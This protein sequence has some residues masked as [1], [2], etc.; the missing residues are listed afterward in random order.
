MALVIIII[1]I[2]F[3]IGAVI[4]VRK[5]LKKLDEQALGITVDSS[6]V[7]TAQE[8]LPFDNISENLLDLGGF[9]Y[10][11]IIE[12]SSINYHLKTDDEKEMIEASFARFLNSLQFPITIYIQTREIDLSNYLESLRTS[13]DETVESFPFL[14]GY[15][16]IFYNEMSRLPELTGN[17]KQKK[18]YII[19]GYDEIGKVENLNDEEKRNDAI[20]ELNLRVQLIIDG[21]SGMNIKATELS[22]AGILELLYTT[23]NREDYSNFDTL[24]D[25]DYTTLMVGMDILRN[26][27]TG[28]LQAYVN[29]N[30]LSEMDNLKKTENALFNAKNIINNE[31][32]SQSNLSPENLQLY[33]EVV[34]RLDEIK[35]ELNKISINKGGNNYEE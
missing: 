21:L 19:V 14:K 24:L 13:I 11:K 2:L 9:K 31:I 33:K 35:E 20:S 1:F 28:E 17:S 32:L 7:R 26:P 18:K 25:G 16:E 12:C 8:F 22:T 15:S 6:Q 23:Y 10:R 30:K 3:I 5:T 27:E 4:A 34:D 29:R